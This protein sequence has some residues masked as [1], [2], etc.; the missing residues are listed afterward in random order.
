MDTEL[1]S[2]YKE[3]IIKVEP[4]KTQSSQNESVGRDLLVVPP[5][6]L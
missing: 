6:K 2:F 1:E 4:C 5:K 3:I